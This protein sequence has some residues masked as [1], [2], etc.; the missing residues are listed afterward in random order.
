MKKVSKLT[1]I[2]LAIGFMASPMA[3]RAGDNDKTFSDLDKDQDSKIGI[4]EFE[5]CVTDMSYD[6]W[7]S[8]ND[9]KLSSSE[10]ARAQFEI[11]DENGDGSLQRD[12]FE[13][14]R[15]YALISYAGLKEQ[16][17][18][19][20]RQGYG[21]QQS[22]QGMQNDLNQHQ[23][24]QGMQNDPSQQQSMGMGSDTATSKTYGDTK[25]KTYGSEQSKSYGEDKSWKDKTKH[26]F[27]TLDKDQNGKLSFQEFNRIMEYKNVFSTWDVDND[28][29]ISKNEMTQFSFNVWDTN[30]NGFIDKDEFKGYEELCNQQISM[31]TE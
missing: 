13:N 25:S 17:K 23:S 1:A 15:S 30:N 5:D 28:G 21:S 18:S 31:R 24:G 9:G 7:D 3:L 22:G 11:L 6:S 26:K 4:H 10:F 8:D 12:E 14:S 2:A 16:S 19:E 29:Q 20:G 27:N